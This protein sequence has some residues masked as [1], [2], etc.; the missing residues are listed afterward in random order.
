M[1]TGIPGLY[2]AYIDESLSQSSDEYTMGGL[3][4]S[5]YEYLLKMWL[6]SGKTDQKYQ[7]LY[8]SA[9]TVS[10]LYTLEQ[11]DYRYLVYNLSND[12]W[13]ILRLP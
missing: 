10:R 12:S 13:S 9:V 4:D 3:A 8:D 6:Y 11:F 5:F 2:P 7:K 1:T